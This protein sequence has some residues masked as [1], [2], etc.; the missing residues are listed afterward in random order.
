[1]KKLLVL[2]FLGLSIFVNAQ[3]N[4]NGFAGYPEETVFSVSESTRSHTKLL[5][6]LPDGKKEYLWMVGNYGLV[7]PLQQHKFL[8]SSSYPKWLIQN[9]VEG[10]VVVGCI[11]EKDGSLSDIKI[12]SSD[13]QLL[14]S[15]TENVLKK[16][17]L[18]PWKIDGQPL[19]FRSKFNVKFKVSKLIMTKEETG[20]ISLSMAEECPAGVSEKFV[21]NVKWEKLYAI[22]IQYHSDFKIDIPDNPDFE[23]LLCKILYNKKGQ[24]LKEMGPVIAEKFDGEFNNKDFKGKNSLKWAING[25]CISY[26]HGKYYSYGY[27]HTL[28]SDIIGHNI[29]YGIKECRLFTISDVITP[30]QMT[31]YGIKE[32]D[33]VDL[34]LNDYFLY[35]GKKGKSIAKISLSQDNW[36]KFAPSLQAILGNKENLP[37]NAISEEKFMNTPLIGVQPQWMRQLFVNQPIEEIKNKIF[38]NVYISDSLQNVLDSVDVKISF[39]VEK[40]GKITN[41]KIYHEKENKQVIDFFS[42]AI[43]NLQNIKPLEMSLEGAVRSMFSIN[44]TINHAKVKNYEYKTEEMQDYKFVAE[45]NPEF[46][47]GV[48]GLSA[49]LSKS[50]KY[51]AIAEEEGIQGQVFVTFI[52]DVDGSVTNI[53]V[54]KSVHPALDKEAVRVVS[55]MPRWVPGELSGKP[56]KVKYTMPVKFGLQ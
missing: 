55:S 14:E 13:E 51:P 47:G 36:D 33:N 30:E 5:C 10:T 37:L 53:K 41:T 24:S 46:P 16:Q 40:D 42:N 26:K 32:T 2:L 18:I 19:R 35:I 50:I 31:A 25:R 7:Y 48:Q 56:V 3:E 54:D 21:H 27:E 28:G 8:P 23:A 9:K 12:L 4:N 22:P 1:M 29:I 44:F 15:V 11:I 38:D 34:G 49:Y 52:I 39:I 6:E 43:S 20:V 17:K 45:K